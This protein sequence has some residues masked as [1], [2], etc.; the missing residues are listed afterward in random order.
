MPQRQVVMPWV[1]SEQPVLV[2]TCSAAGHCR[3]RAAFSGWSDAGP[4]LPP[5]VH[6]FCR[7]TA[8]LVSMLA[9]ALH[10]AIRFAGRLREE[11]VQEWLANI[12]SAAPRHEAPLV[13][14]LCQVCS[15]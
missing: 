7:V 3:S 6:Q 12:R 1:P 14:L 10:C 2:A 13:E 11:D 9:T 15:F 8:L 5:G 4:A